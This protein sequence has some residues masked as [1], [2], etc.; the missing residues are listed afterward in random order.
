MQGNFTIDVSEA[1]GVL[2][3]RGDWNIHI[4]PK[5]DSSNTLKRGTPNA[6]ITKKMLTELG[7]ID[8]WRDFYPKERQFT[9]YSASQ[10]LTTFLP[11]IQTDTDSKTAG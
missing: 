5:L 10:G 1:S 2:I 9:F 3:C 7:M 11:I 8:I 6:K 4:Q